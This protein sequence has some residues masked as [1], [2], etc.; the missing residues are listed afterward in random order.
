[1]WPKVLILM[2][3]YQASDFIDTPYANQDLRKSISVLESLHNLDPQPDKFIFLENNSSDDTLLKL[4]NFDRPKEIIRLWFREDAMNHVERHWHSGESTI[5]ARYDLIGICRQFL[6]Q[7]A[8]QLDPD[9]VIFLDA[10]IVVLSGDL[11]EQLCK[12]GT[13]HIVGGPYVREFPQGRLVSALWPN[14][15]PTPDHPF[16]ILPREGILSSQPTEALAVGGGCMRLSQKVIREKTLN[17][18]P[19]QRPWLGVGP[20]AEDFGYCLHAKALGYEVYI[21]PAI[22]LA[23]WLPKPEKPNAWTVDPHGELVRF[24]YRK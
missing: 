10:D 18:Y 22:K 2:P 20:L 12:P 8:R 3:V 5:S 21:N 4:E 15:H 1:M 17:F 24:S 7:R 13:A 6:L 14:P 11:I 19:V 9:Y 16:Q 23:H